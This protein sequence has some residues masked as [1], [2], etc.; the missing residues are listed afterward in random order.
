M[1]K[2]DL[3]Q[4]FEEYR[5]F[6]FKSDIIKVT[7]A[8]ILGGA[9]DTVVKSISSNLIMPFINFIILQTNSHNWRDAKWVP[10]DGLVFETGKAIGTCVDFL[11]ISLILFYMLKW[12]GKIEPLPPPP[13]KPKKRRKKSKRAACWYI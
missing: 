9:F 13:P 4:T 8:F 3:R 10:I 12:V 5:A 6:A 2:D 1:S 11:L 7:T